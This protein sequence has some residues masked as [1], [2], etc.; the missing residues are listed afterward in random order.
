[1]S[2]DVLFPL[3]ICFFGLLV[4]YGLDRLAS[5]MKSVSMDV[6]A[7]TEIILEMHNLLNMRY[8]E[9]EAARDALQELISENERLKKDEER[10]PIEVPKW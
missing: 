8:R 10:N 9:Y 7:H 3:S 4:L 5:A 2:M 1:M 6:H